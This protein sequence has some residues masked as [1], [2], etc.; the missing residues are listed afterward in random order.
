MA[1]MK[2]GWGK[3][4]KQS[5]LLFFGGQASTKGISEKGQAGTGLCSSRCPLQMDFHC[6]HQPW[7]LEGKLLCGIDFKEFEKAAQSRVE[8]SPLQGF[9]SP[10]EVALGDKGQWWPWSERN[11]P[12]WTLQRFCGTATTSPGWPSTCLSPPKGLKEISELTGLLCWENDIQ[13]AEI[14]WGG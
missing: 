2:K 7:H 10:V 11:F 9:K 12:T 5:V 3:E 13:K 8:S 14:Q 6:H 1:Q 4:W